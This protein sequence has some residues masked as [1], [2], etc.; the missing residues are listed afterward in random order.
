MAKRFI[1]SG[2]FDSAD[3]RH[4][5][6]E[7][8]LF[9]F[10]LLTK[11]NHAGIWINPD[12]E[13]AEF[14]LGGVKLDKNKIMDIYKDDI[15]V[16]NGKHIYLKK[17]VDFQYGKLNPKVK[18]HLSVIKILEKYNIRVS[19]ELGKSSETLKDIYKDKI[20]DID[21]RENEFYAQV[22]KVADTKYNKELL[23]DFCNYWTEKN[24]GGSKMRY[25]KQNTFDISRRLARWLKM[26]KDWNK[27]TKTNEDGYNINDFKFDTTG[28]AR[29]GYCKKCTLVDFYDKWNILKEYSKCCNDKLLPTKNG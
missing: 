2:I 10:Y 14:Q 9:W 1:D 13:L 23:D 5:K 21:T 12:F 7:Y 26:S 24:I 17:Y 6:C 8:K 20:K 16:I 19:K 11:V 18:A 22:L 15:E 25:E 28:N 3:F 27:D 29:L 4:L